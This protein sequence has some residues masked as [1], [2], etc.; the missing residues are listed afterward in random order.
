MDPPE[1]LQRVVEQEH[2]GDE[3]EKVPLLAGAR[4]HREA[5]VDHDQG[6][7]GARADLRRREG[8]RG[9]LLRLLPGAGQARVLLL[10][11]PLLVRFATEGLH[12]PVAEDALLQ[13]RGELAGLRL[14]GAAV[15]AHFF[16]EAPERI[17]RERDPD[18]AHRGQRRVEIERHRDERDDAKTA[19]HDGH[20][21]LDQGVAH[22]E[23]VGGDTRH[24]IAA[25]AA[26]VEGIGEGQ[27]V[28][29]HVVAQVAHDAQAD[30]CREVAVQKA[31]GGAQQ[32]Q[33]DDE[34][35]E[36]PE[37]PPVVVLEDVVEDALQQQGDGAVEGAEE[38]HR[39][40]GDRHA[41]LVGAQVDEEPPVG[42]AFPIVRG[43]V[44][45]CRHGGS[46]VSPTPRQRARR[47]RCQPP[48]STPAAPRSQRGVHRGRRRLEPDLRDVPARARRSVA[49]GMR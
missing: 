21:G 29:V 19:A 47:P 11:A 33:P 46:Q 9:V 30:R 28:A 48:A 24:Q 22:E 36:H 20:R 35:D 44:F 23:G 15:A 42:P 14:P 26:R 5:A 10:E 40:D 13:Q 1:V 2:A 16:A 31:E 43:L 39:G 34:A 41:R 8:Q 3:G 27:Q 37:H 17:E 25:R 7:R 38:H 4:D 49:P 6:D 32:G 45:R 18:E 12:H